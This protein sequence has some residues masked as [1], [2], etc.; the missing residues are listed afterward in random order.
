MYP[1]PAGDD[2]GRWALQAVMLGAELRERGIGLPV[3]E[4][5]VD[6]KTME[7]QAMFGMLGVLAERRRGSS[8]ARPAHR[9]RR[10]SNRRPGERTDWCEGQA[11]PPDDLIV[12][13]T[14][15]NQ[16]CI[17]S[18]HWHRV[19]Q[20]HH[21]GYL[22]AR[23]A[24]LITRSYPSGLGTGERRSVSPLLR[25]TRAIALVPT[26]T[27]PLTAGTCQVI[28]SV[29]GPS[30]GRD[31]GGPRRPA[32]LA[33]HPGDGR[34]P[35]VTFGY[36]RRNPARATL[37]SAAAV[38]EVK[39]SGRRPEVTGDQVTILVTGKC[40]AACRRAVLR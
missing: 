19:G 10:A 31:S 15:N 33:G 37:P 16:F 1:R 27:W 28:R 20:P 23:A 26:V 34:W 39:G 2:A 12:R 25:S 5:G 29:L 11:M 14:Q 24:R 9:Q 35:A 17:R 21:I 32:A 22:R 18:G 38:P 4:Q 6:T 13:A 7:G 36:D 3:I 40:V 8:A 30:R